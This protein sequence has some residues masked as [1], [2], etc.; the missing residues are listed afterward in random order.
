MPV[1]RQGV[2]KYLDVAIDDEV[3]QASE[4]TPQNIKLGAHTH[5][6][7]YSV[8]AASAAQS[9]A[10]DKRIPPGSR[11]DPCQAVDGRGLHQHKELLHRLHGS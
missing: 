3:F 5:Y 4:L 2:K 10:I 8:H 7:P 11:N 6:G 1:I 9:L